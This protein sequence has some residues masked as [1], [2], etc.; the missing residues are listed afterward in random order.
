MA[1]ELRFEWDAG[2]A[3]TNFRKHK[4][5]FELATLIFD[6]PCV[7]EFEQEREHGE[8]RYRAIGE[9]DGQV[10]LVAY[11]SYEES[12]YEVVRLIS[13]RKAEPH[14]RRA[15]YRHAKALR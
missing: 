4:V 5:S 11:A 7:F 12:G 1:G 10:L 15:Y 9:V 3:D 2:K 14:E 13:A 8:V 6:D